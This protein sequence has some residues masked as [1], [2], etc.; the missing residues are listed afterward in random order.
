MF[1]QIRQKLPFSAVAKYSKQW[2]YSTSTGSEVKDMTTNT[3]SLYLPI[4][5]LSY[6]ARK[7]RQNET[8]YEEIRN[9]ETVEEKL[10]K[11]NMPRYYGW[12]LLHLEESKIP[13]G[14]LKYTQYITR[15]HVMKEP[16]LP[17]CYNNVISTEQ[18]DSIVET[19]KNNIADDIAFEYSQ[20]LVFILLCKLNI[21]LF[22]LER[23]KHIQMRITVRLRNIIR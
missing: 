1:V 23:S 2:K 8:W 6:K 22:H 12:K 13:Y 7:R 14:I 5:D 3:E 21:L 20:R 17:T 9:L 10:F 15:T 18:L 16:G 11:V 19:V 4:E